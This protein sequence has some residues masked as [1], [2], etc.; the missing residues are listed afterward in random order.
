MR[1]IEEYKVFLKGINKKNILIKKKNFNELDKFGYT[2]LKTNKK[3][4]KKN[5][6]NTKSIESAF[7]YLCQKE[8]KNGGWENEKKKGTN[9]EPSAQRISNLPNKNK[10]F[11]K[12]SMLPDLLIAADYV[13][14]KPFKISS[15]QIRN[16]IPYGERQKLHIDFRPRQFNYFNFNQFTGFIYLDNATKQNGALQIYPGTHKI[17]KEPSKEIIKRYKLKVKTVNVKKFDIV[18]LNI[19]TWHYGGANLNG[20]KRRTIFINYRERSELQQLNQKKFLSKNL[21]KSMSNEEK[22]LYAVR[23]NDPTQSEFF[24]K[25]RNN[26]FLKKYLKLRD[27]FYHK[28]LQIS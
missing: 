2:I 6:I 10:I 3:F 15:A 13:I 12:L 28:Y 9:W 5:K 7:N 14:K 1:S 26:Y 24:Y 19:Y 8:G 22:Y 18:L 25:Y 20:K 23:K 27:L 11:L 4:W 16:P 17:L 21:I